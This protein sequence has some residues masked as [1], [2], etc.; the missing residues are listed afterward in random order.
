MSE[1]SC[2]EVLIFVVETHRSSFEPADI[3]ARIGAAI[4]P[5]R[6]E[7]QIR[8]SA[9]IVIDARL[10]RSPSAARL[11]CG[12]GAETLRDI[13]IVGFG[14]RLRHGGCSEVPRGRS[15]FPPRRL[16]GAAVSARRRAPPC[17]PAATA[18]RAHIH[19]GRD[20][21]VDRINHSSLAS[22]PVGAR[23]F[24]SPPIVFQISLAT[25]RSLSPAAQTEPDD[26]PA[27]SRR[28]AQRLAHQ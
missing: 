1:R 22:M 27:R 7:M 3:L 17:D 13:A 12:V 20:H 24:A 21:I 6:G 15:S 2:G 18:R 26:R 10:D 9:R 14:C 16:S 11:F 25:W 4:A 19:C 5:R 28:L 23:F 8:S